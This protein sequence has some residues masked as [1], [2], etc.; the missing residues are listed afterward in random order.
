MPRP[1]RV[2]LRLLQHLTLHLPPPARRAEQHPRQLRGYLDG[3][4]K[5]V[6]VIIEKFKL[7]NEFGHSPREPPLSADPEIPL[8]RL[9]LSPEPVRQPRRHPLRG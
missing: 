5:N 2:R 7:R 4:S 6:Q 3:F 8:A 1:R 9:N